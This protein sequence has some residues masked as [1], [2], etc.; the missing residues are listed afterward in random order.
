M[1]ERFNPSDKVVFIGKCPEC[2]V[3]KKELLDRIMHILSGMDL[4]D[5]ED[6]SGWWETSFGANFGKLKMNEIKNL[7]LE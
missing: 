3:N 7:F 6:I 5:D 4:T 2:H 1:K